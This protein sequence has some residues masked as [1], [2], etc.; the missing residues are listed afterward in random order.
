MS[1][2]FSKIG[3]S[4][5]ISKLR[6]MKIIKLE[7]DGDN[8]II[9]FEKRMSVKISKDL[10]LRFISTNKSN[11]NKLLDNILMISFF[12]MDKYNYLPRKQSEMWRCNHKGESL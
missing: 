2:E 4:E 3:W 6:K 5:F 9:R 12:F 1:K 10:L 8:T 11:D 7:V